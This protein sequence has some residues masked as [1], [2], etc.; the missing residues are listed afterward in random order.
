MYDQKIV[1]V[2]FMKSI[3]ATNARFHLYKLIDEIAESNEPIHITGYR[4]NAV[5]ISENYWKAILEKLY[6]GKNKSIPERLKTPV[7][8][9]TESLEL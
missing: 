6:S 8:K 5:L 1:E 7:E 3:A 2:L 4:S 9:S